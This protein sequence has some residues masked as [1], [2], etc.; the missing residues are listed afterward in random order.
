MRPRRRDVL[1]A[2]YRGTDARERARA[3]WLLARIPGRGARYLDAASRDADPNIRIVALRA[4]RRIGG[5]VIP[6]AARLVSD[7]APEV[8]REVAI[9]LRHEQSPR[10]AAL[11]ADLAAQHDGKDRWYLEALGVSADRQWDRYFGAWLDRVG[12][13]WNTPAGRD[14]VWRA[15]STRALPLLEKLATRSRR[16]PSPSACATSARFDFHPAEERQRALLAHPRHS[17]RQLAPSSRR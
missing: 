7:P 2:M 10:A 17:R 13:G 3:L 8:R 14:I 16:S 15:R 9:A 1:A 11:W 12:D 5:D 4:T 6:I